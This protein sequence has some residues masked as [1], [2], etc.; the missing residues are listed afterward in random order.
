MHALYDVLPLLQ[1]Q[2]TC[3]RHLVISSPNSTD[4]KWSAGEKELLKI[5]PA[6][7]DSRYYGQQIVLPKVSV[8]K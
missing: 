4:K 7:R 2:N 6:H 8:K 3:C 1:N 5:T